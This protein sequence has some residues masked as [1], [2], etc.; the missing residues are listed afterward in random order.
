VITRGG[1][2]DMKIIHNIYSSVNQTFLMVARSY[3]QPVASVVADFR[4]GISNDGMHE[5]PIKSFFSPLI[6]V[7]ED[8]RHSIDR[9]VAESEAPKRNGPAGYNRDSIQL[10]Q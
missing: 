2:D 4:R 6:A 10:R 8:F 5:R 7:S 3:F 9:Q 1:G